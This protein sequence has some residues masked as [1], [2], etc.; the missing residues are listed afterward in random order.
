MPRRI[1]YDITY[2]AI[3]VALISVCAWITIPIAIPITLQTFAICLIAAVSPLRLSI[4]ALVVY[5]GI[6]VCGLPVFAGFQGGPAIFF[7]PTGGYLLGFFAL[8]L[9]VGFFTNCLG[10][11]TAVLFFS[12]LGGLLCCYGLG[13][14][15]F[16]HLY[17]AQ[18]IGG[19]L[20]VSVAPFLIPDFLK[21]A[22]ATLLAKRLFPFIK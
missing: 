17:S 11:S 10:R 8:V 18:S 13:F 14:L 3:C 19:A 15:F 1:S 9:I 21:I 12:M 2:V 4:G 22:L 6:G 20:L 16:L 5:I 7:Q